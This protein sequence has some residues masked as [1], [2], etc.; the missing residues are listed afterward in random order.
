MFAESG[1]NELQIADES[2][3][4]G[5]T[6]AAAPLPLWHGGREMPCPCPCPAIQYQRTTQQ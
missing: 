2:R 4:A 6:G 3:G 1:Q 5:T